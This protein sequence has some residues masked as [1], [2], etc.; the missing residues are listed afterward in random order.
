MSYGLKYTIPF[1][2]LHGES[3]VVEIHKRG[4]QGAP[5]ELIAGDSPFCVEVDD[6]GFIYAPLRLSTATLSVVG[7]DYLQELFSIDHSQHRVTLK[8]DGQTAWCGFIA[9]EVYTQDY[10]EEVFAYEVECVSALSILEHIPFATQREGSFGFVSLWDLIRQCVQAV[11]GPYGSVYLPQTYRAS[12]QDQPSAEVL[13]AMQVSEQNFMD[14]EGKPMPLKEVL[15]EVCKFLHWTCAD[16]GGDLYFVDVDY[17]GSYSRYNGAMTQ[18]AGSVA[19]PRSSVQQIGFAG[20]NHTLDILPGYNKCSVR[21]ESYSVGEQFDKESFE[22]LSLLSVERGH[23]N[24]T[25]RAADHYRK[26][27]YLPD[28]LKME[29]VQYDRDSRRITDLT[30]YK[31]RSGEIFG[32]MPIRYSDYTMEAK[33]GEL[34]YSTRNPSFT[35]MI[36]VRLTDND[37]TELLTD[38]DGWGLP[39]LRVRGAST[40]YSAGAFALHTDLKE[41]YDQRMI[42]G[43]NI[44]D[45]LKTLVDEVSGFAPLRVLNVTLRIGDKWFS[46]AERME[47]GQR[48]PYY[49]WLTYPQ[50][51]DEVMY[52]DMRY[53]R[54]IGIAFDAPNKEGWESMR[55]SKQP[56]QPYDGARGFIFEI[57][58]PLYGDLELTVY[59]SRP[60]NKYWDVL[61]GLAWMHPLRGDKRALPRGYFLKD[62]SFSFHDNKEEANKGTKSEDGDRIY[63]NVVEASFIN[64]A[65]EVVLKINTYNGDEASFGKVVMGG[66]YLTDNL[67][68]EVEKSMVRPEEALIRRIVNHYKTP[69]IKLT[70]TIKNDD[71]ITPISLLGD[72]FMPGKEFICVGGKIDYRMCNFE[73]IMI[74]V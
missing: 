25:T 16:W 11:G 58:E 10:S 66:R 53:S 12:A 68:S 28:G 45:N 4:Y 26:R 35:D 70:Q 2:S 13:K 15:E 17:R 19:I 74:D 49:T 33:D 43:L 39:I 32:S 55:D 36:Q 61:T 57:D 22:D 20:S 65:E 31:E 50:G 62:F 29:F 51:L 30:P 69:H 41:S 21:A 64:E 60:T 67:Y 14:E 72:E 8:R 73:V 37:H 24:N 44:I 9:P 46:R 52:L 27:T 5:T 59:T 38:K 18:Q 54:R 34:T 6:E 7:G 63:Q 71:A 3:C 42:P 48:A 47:V 56:E 40:T 1:A 23:I